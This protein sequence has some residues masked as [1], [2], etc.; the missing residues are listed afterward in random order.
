MANGLE[1]RIALALDAHLRG[2]R[3]YGVARLAE[4]MG[5]PERTI[6]NWCAGV[7]CPSLSDALLLVD[8]V[9][10][11]D[12]ARAT[13]LL[14]DLTRI[15]RHTT[16]PVDVRSDPDPLPVDVMQEQ[17]ALGG[18]AAEIASH[19]ES[20][21]AFEARRSL[22]KVR[23]LVQGALTLLG[24]LEAIAARTSQLGLGGMR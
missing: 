17:E 7:C 2:S 9:Q 19:G 13:L 16:H 12:P 18:V 14:A 6:Q 24:K 22:P 15:V 21:D 23:A 20:T 11:E 5:R 1:R 3:G 10:S 8:A 4:Q